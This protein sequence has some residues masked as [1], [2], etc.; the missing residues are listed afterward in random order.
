LFLYPTSPFP[1]LAVI[2]NLGDNSNGLGSLSLPGFPRLGHKAL[3]FLRFRNISH[4]YMDALKDRQII[5]EDTLRESAV[6]QGLDKEG[7]VG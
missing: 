7:P 2:L 4:V 3:A 1:W 6:I 5:I